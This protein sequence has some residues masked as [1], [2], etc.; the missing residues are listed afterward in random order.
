MDIRGGRTVPQSN[1]ISF[2][3]VFTGTGLLVINKTSNSGVNSV[4]SSVALCMSPD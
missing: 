4:F 1:P 2:N 3:A